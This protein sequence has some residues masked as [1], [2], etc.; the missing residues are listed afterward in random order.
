MQ[1]MRFKLC[2][3]VTAMMLFCGSMTFAPVEEAHAEAKAE[4]PKAPVY[5]TCA[6]N[7]EEVVMEKDILEESEINLIAFCV[8]GEAEGESEYGKR[9]AI[10][11]ILNRVDSPYFPDSV[12]EVIWQPNQFSCMWEARAEKC[13]VTDEIR[14]LV[15]EE[16]ENRTNSEVMFFMAGCYSDYGVPMFQ[17]GGHYFSSYD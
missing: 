3:F 14:N 7:G 17:E 6:I 1:K 2:S 4:E 15:C 5:A 13:V 11:T 16:M 12:H 9:L 10:D 8:Y